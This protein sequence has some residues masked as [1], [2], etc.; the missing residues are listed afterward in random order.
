MVPSQDKNQANKTPESY[1]E[2]ELIL[3]KVITLEIENKSKDKKVNQTDSATGSN[4]GQL[5]A[6]LT[7]DR[8]WGVLLDHSCDQWKWDVGV[9][10][11]G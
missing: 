11:R 10:L 9:G 1:E 2:V 3:P 4:L 8:S 5:R 6:D 7:W